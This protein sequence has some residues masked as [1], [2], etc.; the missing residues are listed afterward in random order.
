MKKYEI[1]HYWTYTILKA[2][3]A[4]RVNRSLRNLIRRFQHERNTTRFVEHFQNIVKEYNEV[5]VHSKIKMPP[6]KVTKNNE[7]EIL[8][9]VYS[10]RKRCTSP[11]YIVGQPVRLFLSRKTFQKESQNYTTEILYV[12][13]VHTHTHPCLY[14]LVNTEGQEILGKVYPQELTSVKRPALYLIEKV[15]KK[16]G[17]KALIRFKGMDDDRDEWIS[18]S[19]IHTIKYD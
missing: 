14:S 9:K 1:H 19:D 8:D 3:I 5:R 2:S 12:S 10:Q 18:I 17:E 7:A 15:L 16:D 4:E 13:D 6:S 11:R